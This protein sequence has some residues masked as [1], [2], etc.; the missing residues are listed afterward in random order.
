MKDNIEELKIYQEYIDLMKYI[1][2]ITK[3]YPKSERYCLANKIKY[4]SYD[5]ME[6]LIDSYKEYV[7]KEKLRLLNQIDSKLKF[8]KVLVRISYAN[9][10]ISIANYK[11]WSRKITYICQS[12]GGW[13]IAC[14]RQLKT[15]LMT[16]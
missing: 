9:R 14:Q 6:K 11:A 13:M 5:G 8:M 10:Y 12:L 2:L 3:K 16:N 1:E 15:H 7:L 4:V